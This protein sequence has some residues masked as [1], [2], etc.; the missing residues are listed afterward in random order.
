MSD[1]CKLPL[2]KY[3]REHREDILKV[4][5]G[6]SGADYKPKQW[7]EY[8]AGDSITSADLNTIMEKCPKKISRSDVRCFGLQTRAGDHAEIRRFFLACMIW[9]WGNRGIGLI[10]TENCLSQLGVKGTLLKETMERIKDRKIFEAYEEFKLPY[11]RPAFFTKFFYFVGLSYEIRPL[12]VILD[13][14]VAKF[15]EFLSTQEEYDL[16]KLLVK[17]NR[18]KKRQISSIRSYPEGYTRY[19]YCMDD[20]AKE[21]GCPSADNVE[22]FMFKEGREIGK[23]MNVANHDRKKAKN[24]NTKYLREARAFSQGKG[25]MGQFQIIDDMD[26]PNLWKQKSGL[27]AYWW[28]DRAIQ[29]CCIKMWRYNRVYGLPATWG[30]T[31]PRWITGFNDYLNTPEGEEWSKRNKPEWLVQ[32]TP[33]DVGDVH[34]GQVMASIQISI[35][36]QKMGELH[37]LASEWGIDASSLAQIWI[38]QSLHL[39]TRR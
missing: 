10:N 3:L 34:Q 33:S 16:F 20:W 39:F 19:I 14:N 30:K 22:Y 9:G 21:L 26:H 1:M 24:K 37:K 18:D 17:V 4:F 29:G 13:T 8:F 36:T 23:I 25:L 31:K 6:A 11:C 2:P 27:N 12:P 7:Q 38:L 28:F 32:P 35:T 5:H 15:L